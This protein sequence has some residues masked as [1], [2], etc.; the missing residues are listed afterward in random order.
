MQNHFMFMRDLEVKPKARA[1]KLPDEHEKQNALL[2]ESKTLWW[3]PCRVQIIY[4]VQMQHVSYTCL[5]VA[6]RKA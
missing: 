5:P 6:Q 4:Q 2:A 3:V 1:L